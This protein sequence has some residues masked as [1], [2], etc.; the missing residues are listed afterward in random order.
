MFSS[1]SIFKAP[2][3]LF[4]EVTHHHSISH[5]DYHSMILMYVEHRKGE[6]NVSA[7]GQLKLRR[8]EN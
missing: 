4:H 2:E 1:E 6:K 5:V 3:G 7:D 8:R